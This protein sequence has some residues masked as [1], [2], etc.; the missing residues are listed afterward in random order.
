MLVKLINEENKTE[1][2]RF[3]QQNHG[4]FLQYWDWGVFR[5][6]QQGGW[7]FAVEDAGQWLMA[8]LV[9]KMPLQLKQSVL[10]CPKGPIIS[11]QSPISNEL[12]KKAF[13]LLMIEIDKIAKEQKAAAFQIDPNTNDERWCQILSDAGFD[14]SMDDYQPRHTL[15]LDLRLS[16]DEILSQ[17]HQK[18]RYN[19]NLAKK[20]QVEVVVDN[21]SFKEFFELLKKTEKRQKITMF[22]EQY[23]K[24]ILKLPFVKL[25]LAKIGA[26]I[27]AANIMIFWGDTATYLFGA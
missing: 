18:T 5:G 21:N 16:Q 14:K 27:V 10:Y 7:R 26:K 15:I 4:S 9:C 8:A 23:F 24:N 25:Y 1:W 20:K 2:D 11:N 3:V 12:V 13:N 22:K 6:G 17:M 19:I